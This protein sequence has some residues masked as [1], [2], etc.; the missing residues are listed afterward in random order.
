MPKDLRKALYQ[1]APVLPSTFIEEICVN[2]YEVGCGMPEHID[3]AQYQYNMVVALCD[4]GDGVNI[5]GVFH[6]DEPGKGII[7]PRKSVPHD[8]PAVKHKRYVV[9]FLY[10]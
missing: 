10:A 3:L 5:E 8:V 1:L 7:F 9:I 6:V 2:K 4:H